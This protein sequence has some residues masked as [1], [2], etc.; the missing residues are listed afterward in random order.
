MYQYK[1]KDG[2]K[3]TTL[4]PMDIENP[5]V[6][7]MLEMMSKRADEVNGGKGNMEIVIG[8]KVTMNN[9]YW[10]ADKN[11]GVVFTVKSEPFDIC[12]TICVM[13][14]NYRGGYALDGLTKV[15]IKEETK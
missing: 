8:D 7:S 5:L 14:E 10:V 1:L 2:T 15:T 13:L 4:A 11:R 3:I 12:G 9:K 6:M